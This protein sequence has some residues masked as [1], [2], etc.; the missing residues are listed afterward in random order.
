[1]LD[2]MRSRGRDVYIPRISVLVPSTSNFGV[3]LIYLKIDIGEVFLDLVGH[4][5]TRGTSTDADN[6]EMSLSMDWGSESTAGVEVAWMCS[7]GN[8]EIRHCEVS[9]L[10]NKCFDSLVD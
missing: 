3:L 2:G 10:C 4:Q 8:R 1:M 6:A 5:Q 9:L 7:V